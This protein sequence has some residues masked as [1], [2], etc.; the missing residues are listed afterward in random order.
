MQGCHKTTVGQP[1]VIKVSKI[2]ERARGF[3]KF[4]SGRY[5]ETVVF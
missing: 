5:I 4:F 2:G 3:F 1:G